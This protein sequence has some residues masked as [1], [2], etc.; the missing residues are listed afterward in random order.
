MEKSLDS[1]KKVL[2]KDGLLIMS[3]N[4]FLLKRN[5]FEKLLINKGFEVVKNENLLS[6]EHR[7]D[8]AINRDFI[9]AKK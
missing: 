6:F 3:W 9:V 1:W 5:E 8:Q 7:V 4:T 2:N